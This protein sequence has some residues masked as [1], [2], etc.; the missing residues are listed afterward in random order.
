MDQ[1]FY[2]QVD[3]LS[4]L[5]DPLHI[6]PESVRSDWVRGG[7]SSRE[8]LRNKDF[9]KGIGYNYNGKYWEKPK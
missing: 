5:Q 8:L 3:E 4:H 9:L 1:R 6:V 2:T 7:Q